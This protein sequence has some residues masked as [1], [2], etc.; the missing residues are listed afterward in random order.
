MELYDYIY[1]SIIYKLQLFLIVFFNCKYF[2]RSVNYK[3]M[4]T[5]KQT[6]LI[7]VFKESS[8]ITIK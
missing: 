3:F 8:F 5:F 2:F 7:L 1:L 4:F 6:A